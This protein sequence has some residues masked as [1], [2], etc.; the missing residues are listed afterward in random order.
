MIGTRNGWRATL[1]LT[2]TTGV[3]VVLTMLGLGVSP[4]LAARGHMFTG[5]FASPG[6]GPGQLNEPAG[7][8]V[9]E[10]TGDVYVVD[11]ANDRVEIFNKDGSKFEGEFNGSGLGL[12]IMG[13]GQLL[14]EG[15]AAGS[16]GLP[17]EVPSGR[18]D[19]PEEIAID[20]D[21][22][23]PSFGDVYVADARGRVHKEKEGNFEDARMVIDK[24]SAGGEYIGQI[25]R[26][27]NGEEPP[28]QPGFRRLFGV[29]VDP[30][31]EVWVEEENFGSPKGAANYTNAVA[32]VWIGFRDTESAGPLI[33]LFPVPGFAVDSEDNLYVHSD[34]IRDRLFK[35]NDMGQVITEEVDE[36]APTG[37]AVELS[38]NDVYVSHL[39]NVHRV[40]ATGR[41]LESLTVPG[42]HGSGVGVDSA[43]LMVYVTDSVAGVVDVYE[44]EAPGV[45]TVS[46]GSESVEDVTATSASFS[47]EV[48]PRSEPNEEAT[49]YSFEYG[50]CDSP[51]T[52]ASSPYAD[53]IP[54]PEGSLAAN[55]EPD[56]VGAHPQDLVAHTAYHMRV[57]AHNSH[58]GV[59]EGEE[60]TFTTQAV[61]GFSLPD[62]R[63]WEMV[64]PANKYGALIQALGDV[65]QA[66]LSGD[67]ITYHANAPIEAQPPSNTNSVVQALAGRGPGGWR[68]LNITVAHETTPGAGAPTE[69][70]FFSTDLSVGL[71]EPP[72]AFVASLSSEA[73]EQTLFLRRDFATGEP[74]SDHFCTS[75]CYTPL[76]TG[77]PGVEN[78]PPGTVF[79]GDRQT[80]GE[81]VAGAC[82]PQFVGA[83]PDASHIILQYKW[84]PLVENAP[85]GSLYEW[86]GGSLSVVSVLPD[87]TLAAEGVLGS[88]IQSVSVV[89]NAVSADGSRI[90]WSDGSHLYLRDT[91][92]EETV[93]LDEVQGGSGA[94]VL[95]PPV[96]QTASSD[97]SRVFFV[98]S[99]LYECEI[100]EEA[101]GLKCRLTDLTGGSGE[102]AGVMGSIPG[103]SEDGSYVYFVASGVLAG[104]QA[105]E[106]GETAVAGQPNLY[107]DHD[108][109]TSLVAVLSNDDK[110]DWSS[111]LSKLTA[112][113][114]PDGHWFSFLSDR[115][116]TG[117]DNRDAV[118]G[119]HDEEVFLYRP[120][121]GGQGRLVCASCDPTGGRPH[122]VQYSFSLEGF[123]P[124]SAAIFEH[125]QGV[126]GT[127][128]GWTSLFYQSRY[129]SNSGRLF[130]DS[131]DSLAPQDI[132][133]AEDVYQ[134]EP[135][136]VGGCTATSAT[137][138]IASD[139]CVGLISSGTSKEGSAFLDASG[140]GGDV[141]FLTNAQLSPFDIDS[142]IDIYDAHECGAG[143]DCSLPVSVPVPA[144]EGDACQSPVAPPEDPTPGSLTYQGPGNPQVSVSGV[145]PKAKSKRARCG[146]G[147]V[148]RHGKCVGKRTKRAKKAKR[149][150]RRGK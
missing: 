17:D 38:S 34:F 18:F 139:G 71:L 61:G 118:S 10:A 5:S 73:T 93:K 64:S 106:R 56:V 111:E 133:G 4:A 104:V 126:A 53:S 46:A 124:G 134:F 148:K 55:Y 19:E 80:G 28:S 74:G 43:T 30:H 76:V 90:V 9:N 86:A 143:E 127:L 26:N 11:K 2:V 102:S 116:L 89:R 82:G 115:S 140:P 44:P 101:G 135:A 100:V 136:G 16:G 144:C 119:K 103:A 109:V 33:G 66:S 87:K 84:A 123:G 22:N 131:F 39:T 60:L 137:L 108:G 12:G 20:N 49:S 50:P 150:N 37:V 107:V 68:S 24:F 47:A 145:K 88:D 42:G 122:G 29:A 67:A 97:G 15:K 110:F 23:S 83:S 98:D 65:S 6:S 25:T 57:V 63:V 96:F 81:C 48:N 105:N 138:V 117:F 112:R 35:L 32:N 54:V 79:G 31:G 69:Y 99:D 94:G 13:S 130:F 45:P 8:A 95:G 52:C 75:S 40:D 141:F 78:V 58:P 14:N 21:P 72:G 129:L 146:R 121:D 132:N 113:V 51:T 62:G 147:F 3:S 149:S 59:V 142:A 41:S 92:K 91:A 27:P 128:P 77:A 120:G 1:S 7:V 36:E 114:S 85:A 125:G 70:P